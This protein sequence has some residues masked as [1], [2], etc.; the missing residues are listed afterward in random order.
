M[1]ARLFLIL[2]ASALSAQ[3]AIPQPLGVGGDKLY[4]STAEY[5]ARHPIC[6][7]PTESLPTNYKCLAIG[8]TSV[9][10]NSTAE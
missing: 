1:N 10:T 8:I 5:M 2:A 3:P 7:L 4:E 6:F 9:T